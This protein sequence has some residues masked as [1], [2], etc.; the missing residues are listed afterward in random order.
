LLFSSIGKNFILFWRL[1]RFHFL[2]L[3]NNIVLLLLALS[4]EI[5]LGGVALYD[6]GDKKEK[7]R[8]ISFN[9]LA[10]QPQITD[11]IHANKKIKSVVYISIFFIILITVA[12]EFITA[13]I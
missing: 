11:I 9:D 5:K 2:K 1:S 13:N 6:D 4:L 8:K 7:L 3:N 12:I 10:R